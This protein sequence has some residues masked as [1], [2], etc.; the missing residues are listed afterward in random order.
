MSKEKTPIEEI[1][2]YIKILTSLIAFLVGNKLGEIIS[3][4]IF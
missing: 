3:A 4:I 1:V 2:K